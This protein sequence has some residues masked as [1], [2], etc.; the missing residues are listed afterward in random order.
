MLESGKTYYSSSVIMKKNVEL[1]LQKGSVLKATSDING[2]FRPCDFINDETNTLIG[3]PI[4]GKP[5]FAFIYAYKADNA[6]ITGGGK[7]DA[8]GHSFVKRKD[9]YYVTGDFYPRPTVMYFEACNH[10]VF[11]DFTV[12]DAPFWTLHPAGCDDVLISK[13]HILNDLDVA[14]SDGI[15]PDHCSNVRICDC[16]V[17]CA[18]DCIC[19]KTSKGNSEYGPCE[20]ILITGCTLISTSAAIK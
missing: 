6:T 19:L 20:N 12:V 10:I 15:D 9:K 18:D 13:I 7:I 8:N 5:S 14:N 3:N 1:H 2:Y 4:T 11:E 16:H 17:E